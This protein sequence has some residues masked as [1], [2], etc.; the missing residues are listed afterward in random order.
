[1]VKYSERLHAN[2]VPGWSQHYMDY[3]MLK[4]RIK[5]GN[6]RRSSSFA[7]APALP[8][9]LRAALLT[10]RTSFERDRPA[11]IDGFEPANFRASAIAEA[12]KVERFYKLR[13]RHAMEEWSVHKVRLLALAE[14]ADGVGLLGQGD[15]SNDDEVRER[16]QTAV[17]ELYRS[18][19]RLRNFCIVNYTGFVKIAKKFVKQSERASKGISFGELDALIGSVEITFAAVFTNGKVD[20]ARHRLLTRKWQA[21]DWR[22][23]KR[24]LNLGITLQ[25][26]LWVTWAVFVESNVLRSPTWQAVHTS[27]DWMATQLP[28][29][30]GIFCLTLAVWCWGAL[31]YVWNIGR[32]N[33]AFLFEFDEGSGRTYSEVFDFA[34]SWSQWCLLNFLLFFK[35]L[36][37]VNPMPV[38]ASVFPLSLFLSAFGVLAL[39][40]AKTFGFGLHTVRCVVTAPF[41]PVT[42]WTSF[43]ADALTSLV[44]PMSDLAYSACYFGSGEFWRH[45][46]HESLMEGVCETAPVV[47]QII[48]PLIAALPLWFRLCQNLHQYHATHTRFPWLL[49]GLKYATSMTVVVFGYFHPSMAHRGAWSPYRVTYVCA[50]VGSTLFSFCWDILMDWKLLEIVPDAELQPSRRGSQFE[51]LRRWL[52]WTRIRLRSQRMYGGTAPYVVAIFLDFFLRFIWTTT[53]IPSERMLKQ[54]PAFF[55]IISPFT[56]A[57]EV[58]RRGMWSVLRVES[59]HLSTEGY[60]RVQSVPLDFDDTYASQRESKEAYVEQQKRSKSL[61]IS[62]IVVFAV[63]VMALATTAILTRS[64][65]ALPPHVTVTHG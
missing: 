34:T 49:N 60:R 50:F 63:V 55:H 2:I 18:L 56:A 26:L 41:A 21:T 40:D 38:S 22:T 14:P 4:R 64:H 5:E 19:T 28:V 52:C 37:G 13:M 51:R 62:E 65:T 1:M 30:R 32:V 7:G 39:T 15:Y 61:V 33:F 8:E 9:G 42:F 43:A 10:T 27:N 57:A 47:K 23:F 54:M 45:S 24:G 25:L 6:S 48:R 17:T 20:D 35:T 53:L 11:N 58:C 46:A 59:E 16:V 3:G 44:Q 12:D 31:L 29:Y 36:H